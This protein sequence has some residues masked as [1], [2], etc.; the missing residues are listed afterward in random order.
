MNQNQDLKLQDSMNILLAVDEYTYAL[1][2]QHLFL[3]EDLY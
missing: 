2:L 1:L 3:K